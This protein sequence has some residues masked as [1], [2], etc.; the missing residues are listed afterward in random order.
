MTSMISSKA[1]LTRRPRMVWKRQITIL[2][3]KKPLAGMT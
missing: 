3:R 2:I 1:S